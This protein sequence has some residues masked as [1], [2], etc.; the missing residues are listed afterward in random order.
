MTSQESRENLQIP[1]LA[2]K[3][4]TEVANWLR[5]NTM[6]DEVHGNNR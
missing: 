4:F 6:I 5:T 1:E 3:F 2:E